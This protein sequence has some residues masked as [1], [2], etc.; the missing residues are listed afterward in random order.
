MAV[1]LGWRCFVMGM[2]TPAREPA[3]HETATLTAVSC[4]ILTAVV[5]SIII[6][7]AIPIVPAMFSADIVA[8]NPTMPTRHVARD[9]N[10]FIV[11]RPIARA[12]VVEWPVAN[13][14]FET[15]RSNSGRNKNTRRNKG[16]EQKFVFNHW[17]T[18]HAH[19][20]LANTV[21]VA[22]NTF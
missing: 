11:V 14:D 22:R 3:F 15:I 6:V 12:M 16:D 21:L 7:V 5:A 19:T 20:A 10:H 18:N 8:V 2:K 13:L 4:E 1:C 17:V 9:P